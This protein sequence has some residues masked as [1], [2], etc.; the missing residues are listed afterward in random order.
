MPLAQYVALLRGIGPANPNTRNPRLCAV[1]TGL[2]YQAVK[3]LLS[4]G[5]L[6]FA[7]PKTKTGALERRIERALAD[8]L[9]ETIDVFVRSRDELEALVRSDPFDG[10]EHG[11]SL[12]LVVTFR[13]DDPEPVCT[14]IDRTKMDG[15]E[16][17]VALERRYGKRITTRTWNTIQRILATMAELS[18]RRGQ[19]ARCANEVGRTAGSQQRPPRRH[20]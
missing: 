9:G 11:A 3:P 6:V 17:M 8:K 20:A 4:S 2:G 18:V 15:A 10:A 7:A 14:A 1:L 13:K 5:N 12:Y 16:F 19:A